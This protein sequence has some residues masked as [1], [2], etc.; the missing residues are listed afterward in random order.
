MNPAAYPDV[1]LTLTLPVSKRL[2]PLERGVAL[3]IGDD[4][5]AV[6][7]LANGHVLAIDHIDPF[8]G[9][10]TLARGLLGSAGDRVYVASP[11]HKKRFD[12][13]TGECLDDA[14]V[15]VRSWRVVDD[16]VT[17]DAEMTAT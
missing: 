2:L 3:L 15:R 10:S 12:L 6:F 5:I 4:Q 7:R 1:R 16:H 17:D 11:L 9:T 13:L 14:R 8:T